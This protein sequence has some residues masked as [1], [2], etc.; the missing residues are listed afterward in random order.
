MGHPL[1]RREPSQLEAIIGFPDSVPSALIKRRGPGPSLSPCRIH[2][3]SKPTPIPRYLRT[4]TAAADITRPRTHTTAADITRPYRDTCPRWHMRPHLRTHTDTT[5][6]IHPYPDRSREDEVYS[7]PG[8]F[9]LAD[10]VFSGNCRSSS[11]SISFLI[12]LWSSNICLSTSL[13]PAQSIACQRMAPS[14]VRTSFEC[15][16]FEQRPRGRECA[17]TWL[18]STCA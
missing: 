9:P 11:S 16:S 8:H 1:N 18:P 4:H 15:F 6:S 12:T 7:H 14:S 3:R 5:G 17:C 13:S 2:T 10:G